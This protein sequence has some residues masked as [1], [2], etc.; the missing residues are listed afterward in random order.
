MIDAHQTQRMP[1]LGVAHLGLFQP[2]IRVGAQGAGASKVR[3]P[4][5]NSV[6]SRS[7]MVFHFLHKDARIIPRPT[8][9][10]G[11]AVI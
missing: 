4:L 10:R 7:S 1:A 9:A 6:I 3:R 2:V 5:S 8:C 11:R